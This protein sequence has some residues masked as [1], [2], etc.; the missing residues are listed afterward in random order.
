MEPALRF[1]GETVGENRAVVRD[2]AVVHADGHVGRDGPGFVGDGHVGRAGEALRGTRR[3]W[4]GGSDGSFSCLF[5]GG[6]G[7][8]WGGGEGDFPPSLK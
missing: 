7:V 1:V 5:W 3:A 2:G 6:G 8:V 4:E